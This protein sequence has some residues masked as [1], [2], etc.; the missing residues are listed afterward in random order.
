MFDAR[1]ILMHKS[2][3]IYQRNA[4]FG[5]LEFID[6]KKNQIYIFI[7][8]FCVWNS[9]TWFVLKKK[10]VRSAKKKTLKF[11]SNF[12]SCKKWLKLKLCLKNGRLGCRKTNNVSLVV[13]RS[14]ASQSSLQCN[15]VDGKKDF[16][17]RKLMTTYRITELTNM[18]RIN[19][20]SWP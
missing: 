10:Q 8:L 20:K 1:K 3:F 15:S 9:R 16:S 5:T 6:I 2:F 12:W 17:V 19:Y 13:L 11:H 14:K 4:V 18:L 7:Y